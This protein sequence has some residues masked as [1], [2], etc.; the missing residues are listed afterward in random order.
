MS[1]TTT[2][3]EK[4]DVADREAT[5]LFRTNIQ[6]TFGVGTNITGDDPSPHRRSLDHATTGIPYSIKGTAELIQQRVAHALATYSDPVKLVLPVAMKLSQKVVV[7]KKYVVGGGTTITPEHA[8]ARI[9]S[10]REEEV[11]FVQVRFGS[12][13]TF[14]LNEFLLKNGQGEKDFNQ[15]VDAQI[16]SMQQQ[17][18]RLAYEQLMDRGVKMTEQLARTSVAS[19]NTDPNQRAKFAEDTYTHAVFAAFNKFVDPI[20]T[21]LLQ[22]QQANGFD[23]IPY[24]M[25]LLGA[26]ALGAEKY[27]RECSTR[28]SITGIPS[29]DGLPHTVAMENIK[30]D[31]RTNLMIGIVQPF[32]DSASATTPYA[33][34]NGG[35]LTNMIDVGT[36][37][38]FPKPGTYR[39][40][41]MGG[42][43]W[44]VYEFP[45][46]ETVSGTDV[47][48]VPR[49][50][51]RVQQCVMT[52]AI[53]CKT[54]SDTGE[55][56][57][58]YPSTEISMTPNTEFGQVDIRS[59]FG[60]ALYEP[61]NAMILEDVQMNRVLS[62]ERTKEN[63][64]PDEGLNIPKNLAPDKF[65]SP[66][67]LT[68]PVHFN[69]AKRNITGDMLELSTF[70]KD[71]AGCN[72]RADEVQTLYPG[73]IDKHSDTT[74]WTTFQQNE[75]HLGILEDPMN[76][77]AY[78]HYVHNGS[79]KG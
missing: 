45:E 2:L 40:P 76:P 10:L 79:P 12:A 57:F 43:S 52:S 78:G 74:G 22:A 39:I 66:A 27:T 8:P 51:M 62:S 34:A 59:Y 41:N 67:K 1:D 72:W 61:K 58:G 65:P 46:K 37:Y 13:V 28:F 24:D 75:G 17:W 29:S 55:M 56:F 20:A 77:A 6:K 53:L 30:R 49:V 35:G 7:R 64:D 15:K 11:E 69:A 3:F 14:N 73:R 68:G 5:E 36:Y 48:F 32:P 47:L 31:P 38:V 60:A 63:G 44:T 19:T 9:V 26:G 50:A 54:G 18:N 16:A 70:L 42:H 33:T 71:A 21:L 4:R 25:L 23:N